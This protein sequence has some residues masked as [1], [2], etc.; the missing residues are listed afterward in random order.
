[1]S[2]SPRRPHP[3]CQADSGGRVDD[4]PSNP[5]SIRPGLRRRDVATH[6]VYQTGRPCV[7][8]VMRI[9]LL[10]RLQ[11]PVMYVTH[12]SP[13]ADEMPSRRKCIL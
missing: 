11:S 9:L 10:P 12:T 4:Q 6:E 3:R 13:P 2:P 1:M 8:I 7:P 5:D